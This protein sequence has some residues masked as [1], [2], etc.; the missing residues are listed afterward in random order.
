MKQIH[1]WGQ[2]L[3]GLAEPARLVGLARLH[4]TIQSLSN[5]FD[6]EFPTNVPY[7]VLVIGDDNLSDGLGS[8]MRRRASRWV[9]AR[10]RPTA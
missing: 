9:R 10:K 1:Y 2:I 4:C 8:D 5:R 6:E 7:D 3:H